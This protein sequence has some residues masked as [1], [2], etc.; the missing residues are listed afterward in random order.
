MARCTLCLMYRP[1]S[2]TLHESWHDPNNVCAFLLSV[3]L[4]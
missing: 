2:T 3:H 1:T 4:S